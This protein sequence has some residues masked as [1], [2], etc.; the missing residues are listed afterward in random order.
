[1][2]ADTTRTECAPDDPIAPAAEAGLLPGDKL[3][4]ID[5]HEIT[6]YEDAS[7]LITVAAGRALDVEVL[8][9]GERV[10]LSVTPLLTERPVVDDDQRQVENPDGSPATRKV[11]FIGIGY[12]LETVQ[13]PVTAVPGYVWD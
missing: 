12:A 2:P 10:V 5:G 1:A 9:N 3:V 13:Q 7:A 8:R 11:G 6:G 4:S